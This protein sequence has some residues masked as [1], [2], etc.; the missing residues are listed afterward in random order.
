MNHWKSFLGAIVVLS[1]SCSAWAADPEVGGVK[2]EG[3]EFAGGSGKIKGYIARPE[4]AGPFPG[5]IV[6]HEWWGLTD[7]VKGRA[8]QLAGQGYVALAVDLYGGRSTANAAE[9]HELMRALD[10]AEGL[11]DLKGGIAYLKARPDVAPGKPLGAI[12]WCMGG[13]YSRLAA[14]ESDAI[15]PTVICYGSVAADPAQVAK[16]KGKSILGI[17]GATDRGIPPAKVEAFA[18]AVEEQGGRV[19]LKV[20]DGAGHAFMREGGDQYQ[21]EAAADATKRIE[22]FFA[23]TLKR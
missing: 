3:V 12:G 16:L 11:A 8:D 18:K 14:Q 7:W 22:R 19:T 21:A 9:A 4:G 2:T 13:M 15:G 23:E 6:V 17:F 20:Y 1:T 5:I 10:P